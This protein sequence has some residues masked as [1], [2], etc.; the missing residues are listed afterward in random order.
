MV[1]GQIMVPP[2]APEQCPRAFQ[3]A[4]ATIPIHGIVNI[5][6]ALANPRRGT[7]AWHPIFANEEIL[8]YIMNMLM[9]ADFTHPSRR[10]LFTM[11]SLAWSCYY[12]LHMFR[13]N[14]VG[15]IMH[16]RASQRALERIKCVRAAY[17]IAQQQ[18]DHGIPVN[19]VIFGG[20]TRVAAPPLSKGRVLKPKWAHAS[21]CAHLFQ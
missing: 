10:L 1:L 4:T 14:T 5:Q 8:F 18:Q 12:E 9:P 11:S 16:W 19:M 7:G 2:L 17:A 3:Y 13:K 21:Y 15:L 20:A 6:W